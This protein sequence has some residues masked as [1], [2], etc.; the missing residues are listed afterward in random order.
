[1]PRTY[2]HKVEGVG[3]GGGIALA[4]RATLVSQ[5]FTWN[6]RGVPTHT[7]SPRLQLNI[8]YRKGQ[9]LI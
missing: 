5:P 3:G 9:I 8:C 1:M 2:Q 6:F 7:D 4:V